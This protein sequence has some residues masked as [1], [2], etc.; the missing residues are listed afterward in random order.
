MPGQ[1]LVERHIWEGDRSTNK[2]LSV[3][4]LLAWLLERLESTR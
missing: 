2:Q 4:R 3:E 1:T